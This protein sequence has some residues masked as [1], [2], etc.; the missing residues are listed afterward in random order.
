MDG[1]A[2][3]R[4]PARQNGKAYMKALVVG[5]GSIGRRHLRNLR[6]LG[7]DDLGVVE[8][9]PERRQLAGA[10]VDLKSWASLDEGLAWNPDFVVVATPT[11]LHADQAL[12]VA[13]LGLDLFVEKPLCHNGDSL[14]E[15]CEVAEAKDLITLVG[16]N[17]R[18]HPG[19]AKVRTFLES[20]SLGKLL[21]ARIQVGS[22]LPQWRAGADYRQ[23]YAAREETG[24]GC[25]LDCIHEIDLARWYLG[26][27]QDV[28]CCA[29]QLSSLEIETEDVAA[30]IC[31][32][33]NGAISEIHLDYVQHT[34][35]RNCQIVGEKGSVFWDFHLGSVRWH[36]AETAR[37][38]LYPQPDTWDV[39]EMFVGEMGHFLDCVR[40]RKQSVLPVAEAA[41]V[42]QIVFA[43]KRSAKDGKRVVTAREV[44]V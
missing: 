2:A 4:V 41:A 12:K 8:P 34:Y 43:A 30:L 17:M 39:N 20:G 24:G 37:S 27:V 25:I 7:V 44:L 11:H 5:C 33:N 10:D 38:T 21:F 9:D 35:E 15:L 16:C 29:A 23:N 26:D 36:D 3:I 18:F 42:M 31:R 6:Q 40:A 1:V 14:E 32:H 19:P 13:R 22:Y 28:F